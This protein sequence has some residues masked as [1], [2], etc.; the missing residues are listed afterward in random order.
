MKTIIYQT[1]RGHIHTI[2]TK[3]KRIFELLALLGYKV[4][5]SKPN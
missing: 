1:R 2:R 5:V 3:N 4:L